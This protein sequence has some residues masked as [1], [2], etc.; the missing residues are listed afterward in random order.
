MDVPTEVILSRID[1]S[2]TFHG[3]LY[4]SIAITTVTPAENI[5]A[6]WLPPDK[7]S[8]PNP[9]MT[10]IRVAARIIKGRSETNQCGVL[11][12]I[13]GF[14]CHRINGSDSCH[15]YNIFYSTL[16]IDEMYRLV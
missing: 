3:I 14:T 10:S 9:R 16:K 2:K 4:S 15:V 7:A 8:E 11:F 6:T 5:N 12:I 1:S 13:Y